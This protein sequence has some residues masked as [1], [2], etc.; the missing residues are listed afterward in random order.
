MALQPEVLITLFIW[1]FVWEHDQSHYPWLIMCFL[2]HPTPPPPSPTP[3]LHLVCPV[4]KHWHTAT[5]QRKAGMLFFVLLLQRIAPPSIHHRT[6]LLSKLQQSLLGTKRSLMR[7][8][9]PD[10][11]R[12]GISAD[13]ESALISDLDHICTLTYLLP[14]A[15]SALDFSPSSQR[16]LSRLVSPSPRFNSD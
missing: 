9:K 10:V 12:G 3:S 4:L 5:Q 16:R 1:Q 13:W 15:Y 8:S 7:I 11:I 14:L 6:W 2:L